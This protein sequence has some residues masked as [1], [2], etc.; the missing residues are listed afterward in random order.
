MASP[1]EFVSERYK[2]ESLLTKASGGS[3]GQG[4]KLFYDRRELGIERAYVEYPWYRL[5]FNSWSLLV[6]ANINT[7]RAYE[8]GPFGYGLRR[9]YLS[10]HHIT[11]EWIPNVIKTLCKIKPLFLHGYPSVWIKVAQ[12]FHIAGLK[13]P[14]KG[15]LLC[16]E[17]VFPE[18]ISLLQEVFGPVSVGYGLSEKTVIAFGELK[19]NDIRYKLMPT[20][21]YT[22]NVESPYGI[23]EIAGTNLFVKTMPLIR[24]KTQDLGI[25]NDSEII[26]LDGRIQEVLITK[27]GNCVSG[28]NVT[29]DPFFWDYV[30][31]YQFVQNKPG[32]L[33]IHIVCKNCYNKDIEETL[34]KKQIDRMGS[35]FD[36]QIVHEEKIS[37]TKAGKQRQVISNIK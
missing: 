28:K 32:V 22:E 30:D 10:C 34:L 25:I 36:I 35:L 26:S 18:Q 8:K 31:A 9:V 11:P 13:L 6:Q 27:N 33:E 17:Q 16:S 1:K 4:I 12:E 14:V 3:T 2:V 24:Y 15:V 5:G 7:L 37:K 29:I 20:Y 23:P 21:S 19:N